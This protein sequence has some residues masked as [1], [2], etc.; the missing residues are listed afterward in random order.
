MPVLAKMPFTTDPED[1]EWMLK[2]YQIRAG[3]AGVEV[4]LISGKADNT[5]LMAVAMQVAALENDPAAATRVKDLRAVLSAMRTEKVQHDGVAFE[6]NL[7]VT[8]LSQARA[9][10]AARRKDYDRAAELAKMR[11]RDGADPPHHVATAFLEEGDWQGAA[12]VA[13]AHD[14]RRRK[15]MAGDRSVDYVLLHRGVV[16]AAAWG[17]DD[18][19]ATEF[20][21]KAQREYRHLR[22]KRPGE[23]DGS[24]LEW[25]PLALAGVAEGRLPRKR[26]HVLVDAF[27][28]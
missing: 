19:V 22:E 24:D 3:A 9:A 21:A 28:A 4:P 1:K 15:G 18:T 25:H 14:P 7:G 26:I 17:G 11:S 12:A 10:I 5:Y 6:F 8:A 16:V 20:L 13:R 27:P 23:F 2:M